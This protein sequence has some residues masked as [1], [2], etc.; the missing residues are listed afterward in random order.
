MFEKELIVFSEEKLKTKEEVIHY[1]THLDNEKVTDMD[2]FEKDV[3]EREETFSTYIGYDIGMP[4]AKTS[5]VREPFVIYARFKE[6]IRWGDDEGEDIDQV[7]LLGVPHTE[8]GDDTFANLHL[9]V[10][11]MLSRSLMRDEFR[12][13]LS[14]AETN[15]EVYELLSQIKED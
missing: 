1:L 10:L 14:R 9:K 7:V 5:Y 6:K 13:G 15:D 2:G 8:N 4:H 12:E 3:R 11:A